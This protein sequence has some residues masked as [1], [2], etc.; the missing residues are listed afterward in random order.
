MPSVLLTRPRVRTDV[1]D[2]LHTM[3]RAAGV[4]I[5]E[6][7]MINFEMTRETEAL[8]RA[9]H[10]AARGEYDAIVLSSPTAV[11]FFVERANELGLATS[12]KLKAKLAAVG[13]AT[14]DALSIFGYE[15][16]LPVPAHAGSHQLAAILAERG[17]SG[18]RILLLQSQ[19]GLDIL[20]HALTEAGANVERVIMYY[21]KGPSLGD[22]ARLLHLLEGPKRPEVIA[23][24]SPS[25]VM[26]LIRSL[27]EMSAGQIRDLPA[28]ATIGETTAKAVEETL[29]RRPEIVARKSDQKSLAEDILT[30]LGVS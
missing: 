20:E 27:A 15:T 9:F 23:F 7:P 11:H 28:L 1:E 5:V 3:L 26:Y 24:F 21:T 17:V 18:K 8:D 2:L 19:L 10:A 6:L 25:A 13:R 16:E 22:S 12:L 30:Y 4:E 14:S 29:R